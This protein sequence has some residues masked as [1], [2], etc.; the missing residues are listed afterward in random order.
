MWI[1]PPEILPL[2]LRSRGNAIAVVSQWLWTFLIV[3]ITPPMITS[4]GYKSYIVFAIF[5][6]VTIPIVYFFY[7][8]VC[9]AAPTLMFS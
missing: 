9:I 5:N 4:I 7:P 1:Y 2:K 6:F 3:E 8:E